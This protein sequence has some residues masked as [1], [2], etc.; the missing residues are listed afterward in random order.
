MIDYEKFE[1]E[2][3]F[4]KIKRKPKTPLTGEGKESRDKR[5]RREGKR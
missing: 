2:P 4:E 5:K 3:R 1:S